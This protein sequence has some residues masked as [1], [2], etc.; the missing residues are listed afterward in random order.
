MSIKHNV[1]EDGKV[2]SL[3]FKMVNGRDATVGVLEEGTY[4]LGTAHRLERIK[5]IT[6]SI[7]ISVD[8]RVMRWDEWNPEFLTF[9]EGETIKFHATQ[10]TSYICFYD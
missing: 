1:Y 10:G 6:G 5:V 9:M 3:G 8:G 2:Q 7:S 4:N